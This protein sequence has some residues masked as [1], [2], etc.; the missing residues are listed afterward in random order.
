MGKSD[1]QIHSTILVNNTS[2]REEEQ[3]ETSSM[4]QKKR[5]GITELTNVTLIP[6][7]TVKHVE[8]VNF[9]GLLHKW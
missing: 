8:V 6:G 1:V 7:V 5:L 2:S 9:G 4:G 3:G